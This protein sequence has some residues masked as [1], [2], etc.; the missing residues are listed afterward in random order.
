MKFIGKHVQ[1]FGLPVYIVYIYIDVMLESE[2]LLVF[3]VL[4]VKPFS[5]HLTGT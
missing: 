3:T 2:G 4:D 5:I 1:Q